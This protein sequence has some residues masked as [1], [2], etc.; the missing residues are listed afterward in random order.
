MVQFHFLISILQNHK[1]NKYK[2]YT[3]EHN[4]EAI[5]ELPLH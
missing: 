1:N 4:V 5:H 3:K 2:I